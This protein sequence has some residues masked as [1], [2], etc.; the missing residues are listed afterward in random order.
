MVGIAFSVYSQY[1]EASKKQKERESI[2][3]KARQ[4][5]EAKSFESNIT[6]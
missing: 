4:A 1:Q 5:K 2:L 3:V 6:E